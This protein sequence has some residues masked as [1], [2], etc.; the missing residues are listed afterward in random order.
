M[1]D[2]ETTG[3]DRKKDML[4]EVTLLN[5]VNGEVRNRLDFTV[6]RPRVGG[7][8]DRLVSYA[9]NGLLSA[10]NDEEHALS[11]Q[12]AHCA[13]NGFLVAN[14]PEDCV[15]VGKD[16][17]Q[18]SLPFLEEDL[19]IPTELFSDRSFDPCCRL[20]R[21]DDEDVPGLVECARRLGLDKPRDDHRSAT[22]AELVHRVVEAS[23]KRNE[24]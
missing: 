17:W 9:Q 3:R 23:L 24:S 2:T 8:V 18:V 15:A 11:L 1:V 13:V 10:A 4:L 21:H 20:V 5:V 19:Q 14:F 6:F 7:D 22:G 12:Q 16:V